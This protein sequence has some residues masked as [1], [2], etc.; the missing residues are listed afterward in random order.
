MSERARR[1]LELARKS[2]QNLKESDVE[3]DP[4][5]SDDS[6]QDPDFNISS[7]EEGGTSEFESSEAETTEIHPA[8]VFD[9]SIMPE[10]IYPRESS[11]SSSVHPNCSNGWS[12]PTGKYALSLGK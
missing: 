9:E 6:L 2:Y 12:D 4:V 8:R 10:T 1:I 3:D 11:E 7:D 5:T